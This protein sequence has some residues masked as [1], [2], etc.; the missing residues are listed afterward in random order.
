MPTY[1]FDHIHLKVPNA[2][3]RTAQFYE[4]EWFRR[5][6]SKNSVR[7]RKAHLWR[8][9]LNGEGGDE[10]GPAGGYSSLNCS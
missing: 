10:Y 5:K 8:L 2:G 6:N 1:Q 3:A 7:G 4:P 9:D